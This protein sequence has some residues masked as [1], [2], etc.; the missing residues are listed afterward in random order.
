MPSRSTAAPIPAEVSALRD[1]C[2]GD[3]RISIEE[4]EALGVNA[5]LPKLIKAMADRAIAAGHGGENYL[6]VIRHKQ[7]LVW[8]I[9]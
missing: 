3:A 1:R 6:I 4:S 2:A 9:F 5:E 7:S 8:L